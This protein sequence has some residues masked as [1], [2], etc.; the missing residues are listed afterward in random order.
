MPSPNEVLL[1]Y[2]NLIGY[3]RVVSMLTSFVLA[4]TNWRWSA[5]C[6]ILAFAGDAIDGAVARKFNQSSLF[7]GV[8]DMVTDRVSTAGLLLILGGFYPD[9]SLWFLMLMIL[10]IASHWMHVSSVQGHHKSAGSLEGRN[11][12]LRLFYGSYPFFAYLCVGTEVFYIILYLLHFLPDTAIKLEGAEITLLQVL[13]QKRNHL[14]LPNLTQ[15]Y[16][17]GR[18]VTNT[19]MQVSYVCFPACVLK[20]A[21]NLAQL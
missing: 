17:A 9:L 2:P 10:D 11:W 3:A 12:L 14:T 5:F 18:T 7:G 6:Y 19:S 4:T 16:P 8:L 1:Y 15:P 13:I 21:V 20:Q